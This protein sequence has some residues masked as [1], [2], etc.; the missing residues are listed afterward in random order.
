MADTTDYLSNSIIFTPF[1]NKVRKVT[2]L[3]TFSLNTK[4]FGNI[5]KS[6]AQDNNNTLDLLDE[7]SVTLGKYLFNELYFESIMSFNKRKE[8]GDKFFLPLS[9]QN[10]GLNLQLMLQLELP[11]ISIGY[12]FLV[13]SGGLVF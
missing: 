2:G 11:Y 9:N 8:Y 7:S 4:F 12:S 10:Y 3:D 5:I 6:N 1:E 13:Y